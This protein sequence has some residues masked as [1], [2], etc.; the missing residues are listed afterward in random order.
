MS[1][2]TSS[3]LAGIRRVGSVVARTLREVT[4][5]VRIG[6]RTTALDAIPKRVFRQEGARSAPKI[7]YGF[8]GEIL[9]SVNDEVV[10]EI[11]SDYQ[12]EP[13]ESLNHGNPLSD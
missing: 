10:H 5:Q 1:V 4:S 3:D 9:I 8:P 2:E 12:V 7:T 6:V 11:P 13:A